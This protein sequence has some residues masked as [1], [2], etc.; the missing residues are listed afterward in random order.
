M[1]DIWVQEYD[2]LIIRA[3]ATGEVAI[4]PDEKERRRHPRFKILGGLVR[5]TDSIQRDIIDMSMS[6]VAFYSERK[7]EGGEVVPL[8]LKEAF[9]VLAEV[10]GCGVVQ[11]DPSFLELAYRVRCQFINLN[12]GLSFLMLVLEHS[13]S[14]GSGSRQQTKGA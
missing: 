9:A 14:E 5:I 2:R 6:G 1:A 13:D 8:C 11:M 7:Y 12:H 3:I 10:L 4:L